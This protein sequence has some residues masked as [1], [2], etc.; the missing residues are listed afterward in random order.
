MS[1]TSE[2]IVLPKSWGIT[3]L[4]EGDRRTIVFSYLVNKNDAEVPVIKNSVTIDACKILRYCVNGRLVDPIKCQ[5]PPVLTDATLLPKILEN[6]KNMNICNGLGAVNIYHS[7]VA[8]LDDSAFKD[9]VERWHNKKCTMISNHKRCDNC[10]RM[11]KQIIQKKTRL[12]KSKTSNRIRSVSNPIDH[13]KLVALRKKNS[14]EKHKLKKSKQRVQ[15]LIKSLKEK[16]DEITSIRAETLD[17]KFLELDVPTAQRKALREI[18][19][20]A[21]KTNMK[22]H[23]YSEEWL[24]LCMLMNIRSPSNYEFIQKNNIL[25]LPCTRTIRNYFSQINMEYGFDKQFGQLLKKHLDDKAPLK[26]HGVL[27][28]D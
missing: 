20:A 23:R 15:L 25:P 9:N 18:I 14:R 16:S 17:H 10:T 2:K 3:E 11:R 26:R 24:M 8:L 27:L 4:G 6:F 22:N 13:R 5:L 21:S 12:K 19:T 28:L 1:E 7:S